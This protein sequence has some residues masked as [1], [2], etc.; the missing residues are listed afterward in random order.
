MS[1]SCIPN[2]LVFICLYANVVV[3]CH[4]DTANNKIFAQIV[5]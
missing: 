3:I 2:Y 4:L 1:G 5:L